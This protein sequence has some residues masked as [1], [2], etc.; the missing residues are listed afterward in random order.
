MKGVNTQG[1]REFIGKDVTSGEVETTWGAVLADRL[2]RNLNPQSVRSVVYEE[3]QG[4]KNAQRRYFQIGGAV[5]DWI[6]LYRGTV[7]GMSDRPLLPG[8]ASP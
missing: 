1:C 4:L 3:Q 5:C 2:D 8:C 6:L 7:W